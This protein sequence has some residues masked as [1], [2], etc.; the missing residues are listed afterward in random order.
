M[1]RRILII[2]NAG[3][4]GAANYC[5]GVYKD[6]DNYVSFFKSG[7]GGYYSDSEIRTFD[8]PTKAK[9]ESELSLLTNDEI[10]FSII[11]FCGHGWYSTK[12]NSNIFELNDSKEQIDSLKFR[13]GAKKRIIIE[14]NCR[15][16][17]AEYITE[18]LSKA[19]STTALSGSKSQQISPAECKK[20]YNN[21]I[22]ECPEQ[23]IIGQACNIGELA[24]DSNS[25]GGY[26]SGSLLKQTLDKAKEDLKTI[27]LSKS[28][29][30]YNFPSSHTN[31]IPLV[32]T[33]SGN[34]QNPQ[35]E[36][37]RLTDANNYLPFAVIA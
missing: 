16:P 25:T 12:S 26:Y 24:G 7:Y 4:I 22:L 14:D 8:K 27:D 37:P 29:K 35:I 20:Y 2:T 3:K 31:A 1:K 13:L 33:R 15:E 11:I 5:Q 36:K 17:Y 21:K 18:S 19:F 34:K 32:R 10:E 23:I 30:T 9:V 6:K 28:F